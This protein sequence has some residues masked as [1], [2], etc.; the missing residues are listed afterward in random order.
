MEKTSVQRLATILK[1]LV[2]L[3]FACNILALPFVP[4]LVGIGRG[5]FHHLLTLISCTNSWEVPLRAV[6]AFLMVCW[7]YIF[8]VWREPS[9]AVLAAFLLFC[10]INTACILW[11]A[12]RV[13][14]TIIAAL[15]FQRSN[16]RS[17]NRAAA[18]FALI[19]LAALFRTVWGFFYYRSLSPLFT[20]NALFVPVFAMGALLCL[21]MSALF[22]QAADLKED[23]DLTI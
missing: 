17:M 7:Q 11:Q 4:G 13:L 5:G 10:G 19:S 15:P 20:Y 21:V 1:L 3:A 8:R 6:T 2:T 16:A 14:N 22:R 18:A 12:R 9:Y 23:S